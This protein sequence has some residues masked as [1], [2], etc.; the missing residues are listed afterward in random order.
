MVPC[1]SSGPNF[2]L[3]SAWNSPFSSSVPYSIMNPVMTPLASRLL[4]SQTNVILDGWISIGSNKVKEPGTDSFVSKMA[5]TGTDLYVKKEKTKI[6]I[7][8]LNLSFFFFWFSL[9][10]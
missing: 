1:R 3:S 5:L 10:P 2:L 8:Y 7:K 6:I 4:N 9:A